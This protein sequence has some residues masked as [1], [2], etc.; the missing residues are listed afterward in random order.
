M[1]DG[2]VQRDKPHVSSVSEVAEWDSDVAVSVVSGN[3]SK[4]KAKRLKWY[5]D[6]VTTLTTAGEQVVP[7]TTTDTII[8]TIHDVSSVITNTTSD[9]ATLATTRFT[10]ICMRFFDYAISWYYVR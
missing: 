7:V 6:I 9:Q 8:T 5:S 4:S 1:T 3:S 2:T 10:I